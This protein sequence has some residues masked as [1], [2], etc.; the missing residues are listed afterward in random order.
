MSSHSGMTDL[1]A[2][3]RLLVN[4]AAI[5][6]SLIGLERLALQQRFHSTREHLLSQRWWLM[7]GAALV[8]LL[9]ARKLGGIARWMPMAL[10]AMRIAKTFRK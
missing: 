4:Q 3:K 2:R 7:G 6:R 10:A 5:H 1:A 9:F 8:G